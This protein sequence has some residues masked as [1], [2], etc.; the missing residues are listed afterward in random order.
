MPISIVA[1]KINNIQY[2]K[3][4]PDE[5]NVNNPAIHINKYES[6][7]GSLIGVLNL[8]IDNAPTKPSDKAN[9]DFTIVITRVVVNK[10]K[11][12]ILL[13]SSRLLIVEPYFL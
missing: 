1:G 12:K 5:N 4:G 10:I 11:G 6:S 13:N 9:E 2:E 7:S 8:T 3:Y